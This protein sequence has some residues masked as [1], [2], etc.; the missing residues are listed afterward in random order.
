MGRFKSGVNGVS[1]FLYVKRVL[2]AD[3]FAKL[4]DIEARHVM[5]QVIMYCSLDEFRL[6][7]I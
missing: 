6:H 5:D 2:K 1:K 4:D 7:E 3:D